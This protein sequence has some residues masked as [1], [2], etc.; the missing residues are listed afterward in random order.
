MAGQ[1]LGIG[2][3]GVGA[4]SIRGIVPH[5]TQPDVASAVRVVALCDQVLDRARAV[6]DQFGI[7]KVYGSIDELLTDDTVE[8]VSIASPIGLHYAHAKA[9]LERGR[10]IHVNK[11]MTTT[12]VQADELVELAASRGLQIV[13]SPGEALRPN[14]I[15]T[16]RLIRDGAIGRLAWAICGAAFENY[17]EGEVER[18]GSVGGPIDPT[19]YFRSPGGGP[20][21][22]MTVYAL[23]QLTAVLGP[24]QRVTGMSGVRVPVRTFMGRTV[25]TE[26][27][28]NSALLVDFGDSLFAV[29]YGVAAGSVG[30][31]FGTATYFGTTGTVD[32]VLIDGKPFDFPGREHTLDAP[33]GDQDGL[34]RALPHVVGAHRSLPEAHVFEDIMQLVDAVRERAT[35]T[36][37]DDHA[38]HVI[39]IIES[40]YRAADTGET[41]HLMTSFEFE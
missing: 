32:G 14:V 28:D 9:A 35:S 18:S 10:H 27:P 6:G 11:T 3:V 31:Q 20:M 22:D 13:A 8:A 29:V 24:A 34:N 1:P 19:W 23:H 15:E 2:I 5:L 21:Y 33:I 40:G 4:L 37:S 16:R 38:R 17:H 41:Q 36:V 39:E 12:V 30:T 7:G 26:A 25:P